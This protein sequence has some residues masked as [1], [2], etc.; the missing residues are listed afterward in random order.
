[1]STNNL[2][3]N[4]VEVFN[5]NETALKKKLVDAIKSEFE[6]Y[7]SDVVEF[8]FTCR[9]LEEN[10]KSGEYFNLVPVIDC[11]FIDSDIDDVNWIY[12]NPNSF[13]K[14]DNELIVGLDNGCE[15]EINS[16]IDKMSVNDFY[17]LL[18]M[19]QHPLT[20]KANNK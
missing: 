15:V 1:M 10:D 9:F 19:L 13:Q 17:S 3:E 18:L 11:H 16:L 14:I 5:A 8:D 7:N 6:T 20:K 4:E 12:A 2:L